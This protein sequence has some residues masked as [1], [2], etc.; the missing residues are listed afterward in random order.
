MLFAVFV[1]ILFR[2]SVLIAAATTWITNP[3]TFIPVNFII[4]KVGSLVSGENNINVS[5]IKEFNFDFDNIGN[6]WHS[7]YSWLFS[8]GK[9]YLIELPIVSIVSAL[10]GYILVRIFWRVVVTVQYYRRRKSINKKY[11]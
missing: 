8:L 3:L 4:Y 5:N 10:L 1:S 9:A 11:R 2:A 7:F 6:M